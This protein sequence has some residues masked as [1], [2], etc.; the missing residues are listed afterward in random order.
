MGYTFV[1]TKEFKI[2]LTG[3][4]FFVIIYI[5]FLFYSENNSISQEKQLVVAATILFLSL[6]ISYLLYSRNKVSEVNI[7][8]ENKITKHTN[9]SLFWISVL[10]LII[11]V[12]LFVYALVNWHM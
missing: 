4:S 6:V 1:M 12:F 10:P 8:S 5:S 7:N 3:L 2:I 9:N 11:F